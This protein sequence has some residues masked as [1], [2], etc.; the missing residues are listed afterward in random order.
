[1][2]SFFA[3]LLDIV[4]G[5]LS[6]PMRAS[7][8]VKSGEE[9]EARKTKTDWKRDDFIFRDYFGFLGGFPLLV[10]FEFCFEGLLPLLL[11]LL[12]SLSLLLLLTG[13]TLNI[14]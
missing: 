6:F 2:L 7:R 11:P 3:F 8:K 13:C 4:R 12:L 1:M 10:G 14:F 9:K 5:K